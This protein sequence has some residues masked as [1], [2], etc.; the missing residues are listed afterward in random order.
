MVL[1]YPAIK[2]LGIGPAGGGGSGFPGLYN[3]VIITYIRIRSR[4]IPRCKWSKT[5][6]ESQVQDLWLYIGRKHHHSGIWWGKGQSAVISAH[7]GL[8]C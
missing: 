6:E 7:T 1:D 8:A 5:W 4:W 2:R 3:M